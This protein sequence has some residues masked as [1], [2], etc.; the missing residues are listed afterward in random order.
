MDDDIIPPLP[1]LPEPPKI[2]VAF[3]MISPELADW[4]LSL[5]IVDRENLIFDAYVKWNL[6]KEE[7]R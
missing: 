5:D 6:T 2:Y 7:T 1:P 3:Q 4:L